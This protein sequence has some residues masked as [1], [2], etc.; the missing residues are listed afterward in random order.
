LTSVPA[1]RGRNPACSAQIASWHSIWH[2]SPQNAR[3]WAFILEPSAVD[4]KCA[5]W[6]LTWLMMCSFGPPGR[7]S[8]VTPP[9][10]SQGKSGRAD[11]WIAE[12]SSLWPFKST[13]AAYLV[14]LPVKATITITVGDLNRC[15]DPTARGNSS[16]FCGQSFSWR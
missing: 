6:L 12:H 3:F 9:F 10:F 7:Y 2:M 15:G 14:T 5:P 11:I 1:L 4:L 16:K 8:Y 13:Q